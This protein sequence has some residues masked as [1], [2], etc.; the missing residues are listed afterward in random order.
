MMKNSIVIAL[1]LTLILSGVTHAGLFENKKI[2]EALQGPDLKV[3]MTKE[4]L[5]AVIGYP[6]EGKP[7]QDGLFY[8]FA[9][10]RVTAAG[11]EESW[12]YQIAPSAEGVRSVTFKLVDGKVAEWNEWLDTKK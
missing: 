4:A 9:Q 8:R 2:S 6:P 12:T 11:K 10:S 5:V 3:G 7:K 1:A